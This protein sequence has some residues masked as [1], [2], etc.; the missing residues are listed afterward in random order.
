MKLFVASSSLN[1]KRVR[2]VMRELISLGHEITYDWT[3]PVGTKRSERQLQ[4][5]RDYSGVV[6]AD[7]LVIVWPGRLGTLTEFGIA[8]AHNLPVYL[9]GKPDK[10]NIYWYH[11]LV[12]KIKQLKEIPLI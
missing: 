12:H 9:Y 11:P 2:E 6:S 4:T 5:L 1:R 7:A 3:R 10:D 8:L